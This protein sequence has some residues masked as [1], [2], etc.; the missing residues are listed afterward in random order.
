MFIPL[1][2]ML[3]KQR[4]LYVDQRDCSPYV[5]L[6]DR[7]NKKLTLFGRGS[8]NVSLLTCAY[9]MICQIRRLAFNG[10]VPTTDAFRTRGNNLDIPETVAFVFTHVPLVRG[11]YWRRYS[12]ALLNSF[13]GPTHGSSYSW[14]HKLRRRNWPW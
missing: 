8:E 7:E 1:A 12:I 6:V 4:A 9:F 3:Q 11:Y 14:Y 10:D 5:Q 2:Q 13:R